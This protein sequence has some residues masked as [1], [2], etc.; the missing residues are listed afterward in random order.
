MA[1]IPTFAFA[2]I[3]AAL[4]FGIPAAAFAHDWDDHGR[5]SI[6][7]GYGGGYYA[8]P[9]PANYGYGYGYDRRAA[10]YA[11]ERWEHEQRERA[12][13]RRR[14]WEHERWEEGYGDGWRDRD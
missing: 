5:V 8:P 13:A 14:H 6:G 2:A 10:W 9:P 12:E 11:H 4:A 7:F 1:R 3:G